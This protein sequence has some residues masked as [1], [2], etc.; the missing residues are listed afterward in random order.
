MKYVTA[1]TQIERIRTEAEG[2]FDE[3]SGH[4]RRPTGPGTESRH[5]R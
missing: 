4:A 5:R 3:G 1:L 2:D